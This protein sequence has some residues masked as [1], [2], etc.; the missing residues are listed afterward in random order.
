MSTSPI[1]DLDR[2]DPTLATDAGERVPEPSPPL[3]SRSAAEQMPSILQL[4]WP[5]VV[6]NLLMAVVGIV[7]IKIVGSL[8]ASAVAAVTTGHRIFFV[9]QGTLMALCAGT[10]ALVARAWGAD[11]RDEAER[12]TMASMILCSGLAL[13]IALPCFFFAE[14]MAGIF[15]LDADTISQAADFIRYMSL[16]NVSFAV[17][18]VLGSAVRAAG[19]TRT[20][21]WIGAIT[22]VVNVVLVYGLVYGKFGLPAMGVKGAAIASG[23]AF[24]VGALIFAAMW[25]KGW[26]LLGLGPGGSLHE[27]RIRSLVRVGIPAGL[28]Q[29]IMQVGF[30]VFLYIVSLYGTAPYAA[31]GIGVQLL[32]LSF[33]VGFGFSIAASTHVGQRLGA[34]DPQGASRSGWHAVRL[35]IGA[36]IVIGTV[37][38]L[39]ANKTAALMIDDPEV[40]RLTVIFIYILGAV[41]PLMAIE[42][43]LGG[44]LRG[45]GDTRFPMWTTLSGLVLVRG[46]VAAFGAYMGLSVE[47]I[48]AALIVDYIVKSTMLVARFH[49][50]AWQRIK[51]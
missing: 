33:V 39:T 2:D 7:D 21:L 22:N 17:T 35:S 36:M 37:I 29:L 42:F 40:I 48:F 41:Q 11:D 3:G 47:W 30:V 49:S 23:L 8:G 1:A 34:N 6:G 14:E 50:G 9:F 51:I 5:A 27:S 18:L 4:A 38:I 15:K 43:T 19:D 13:V 16:F 44:A 12:V 46:S 26:L 10:T 25:L 31:Y 45:A 32:S 20:P 24:S 28:E